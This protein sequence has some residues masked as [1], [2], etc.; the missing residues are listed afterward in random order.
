MCSSDRAWD[1]YPNNGASPQSPA[2][3]MGPAVAAAKSTGLPWGF[4]EFGMYNSGGRA[5]WLTQVGNYLMHSGAS[6][7]SMF[8]SS[9]VHPSYTVSDAA[10]IAAWRPFVQESANAVLGHSAPT[11]SSS[12]SPSS[13][14]VPPDRSPAPASRAKKT[15]T[16]SLVRRRVARGGH[17]TLRLRLSQRADVTICVLTGKGWVSGEIARPNVAAGVTR[18]TDSAPARAGT[19]KVMVVASNAHGSSVT[20]R[21]LTVTR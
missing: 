5:A 8:D 10:S 2:Q 20:E 11:P 6:F 1:A 13:T 3:F 19:Y 15:A 4:A 14:S 12:P 7:G 18:V 17:I 16:A 9:A 21:V